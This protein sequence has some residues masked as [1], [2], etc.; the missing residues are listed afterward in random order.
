MLLV[1]FKKADGPTMTLGP[2]KLLRFDGEELRERSGGP[3]LA[4]H[5]GHDWLVG[6]DRFLRLDCEG[7][8]TLRFLGGSAA[9]S[10]AYGAFQHFSSVDGIGYADHHVFCQIDMQTKRWHLRQDHSEWDTLVVER[11]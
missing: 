9:D 7:P 2:F 3:L 5:E 8:L 6:D 1:T 10:R 11:P 4:K